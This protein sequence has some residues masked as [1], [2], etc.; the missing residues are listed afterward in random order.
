MTPKMYVIHSHRSSAVAPRNMRTARNP[1]APA[2]PQ[3]STVCCSLLGTLRLSNTIRKRNMLSV[4]K[5]F[6]IRYVARYSLA[7]SVPRK[8]QTSRL[9]P[10]PAAIQMTLHTRATLRDALR[11][12]RCAM[13]SM[14]RSTMTRTPKAIHPHRGISLVA[15]LM[16][17]RWQAAVELLSQSCS[18]CAAD[19]FSMPENYVKG[20]NDAGHV[21]QHRKQDVEP[22]VP[23]RPYFKEYAD[24]R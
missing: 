7:A 17:S 4:L 3:K 22:E 10:K 5:A 16:C 19:I 14:M 6:S 2:I 20:M 11:S 12:P 13:W 18:R 21:A 15:C 24:G 23:G 9:K 8:A 1:T